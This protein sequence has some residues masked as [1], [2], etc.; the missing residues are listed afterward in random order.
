MG[1]IENDPFAIF[2]M[3]PPNETPA[4]KTER[5]RREAE[6]KRVSDRIDEEIKADKAAL[7]K[8]KSVVK[9]LLLGQSESGK[10]TTLKNFRMKY[11]RAA[12]KAE[13]ASWRAVIQLNLIRSIIT[14]VETLQAEMDGT[15]LIED[16]PR[17][18]SDTFDSASPP[19]PGQSLPY[20]LNEKHQLL[21]LRL[22]PLRR[23]EAD[24]KRRLG[25]GTEEVVGGGGGVFGEGAGSEVTGIVGRGQR[26]FGVRGWKQV[27]EGPLAALNGTSE[28]RGGSSDAWDEAT[29]VIAS[30][31]EDMIALW[32]DEPVRDVLNRRR[33]RLEHSAGFFLNDLERIATRDYEP[34]DDDI[35]RARLRTLGIQEYR[36]QFEPSSSILGNVGLSGEFGQEWVLYDV[37][38]SRTMRHKWVPYF[39]GINAIIFLAPIS[40]F[41]ERLLEDPDVNRLEDSFLLWRAVC[42]SKLLAKTTMILFLNKC[43]LLKRKLKSGAE[44]RQFLPSY[45]DRPNDPATVVKYLKEKFK[46][47]LKQ[48]SP[49]PRVSYF[50]ATSVTDTKATATTLKTVRDSI[51]REHLKSADFV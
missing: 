45:G 12:W 51:L 41:D 26:E 28:G 17:A 2:T 48:Q 40:C 36:I 34:S 30:C 18:S 33:L 10:S 35:M 32:T 4:E 25:A 44:V 13:R 23:V 21:K 50:Y 20:R 9:V 37:G 39:E 22:G 15:P 3:P 47:I 49:E 46:D 5:V 24:L 27:L 6:E 19:Q 38:G 7:K 11:A 14:I 29:E 43:D 1:A 16:L 42:G 31:K 8:Q